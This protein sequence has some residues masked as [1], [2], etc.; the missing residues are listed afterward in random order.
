MSLQEN[1]YRI[2]EVMGLH[3]KPRK[4]RFIKRT[5]ISSNSKNYTDV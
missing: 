3:E 1:I 2:K 5:E 4:P